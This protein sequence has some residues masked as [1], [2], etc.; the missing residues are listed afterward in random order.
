LHLERTITAAMRDASFFAS[1]SMIRDA[2]TRSMVVDP[3]SAIQN[4][5][6]RLGRDDPET[7]KLAGIYRNL[8]HWADV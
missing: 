8:I 3:D 1:Q 5:Y 4:L 6:E 2:H 7:V